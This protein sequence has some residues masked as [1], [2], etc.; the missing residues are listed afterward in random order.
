M[1]DFVVDDLKKWYPGK[2]FSHRASNLF[3][4]SGLL[5]P[6]LAERVK[7]TLIEALPNVLPMFSKQLIAYTE[8]TFKQNKIDLLTKTMVREIKPKSVVVT[9]PNGERIE[10]PF[11]L[12]VW[13]GGNTLRPITKDLIAK[14]GQAQTNRRGLTV[15]DHMVLAGSNGSIYSVGDCTATSYAPTAQV[16]AQQG[17]YVGKL[18]NQMAEI[19]NLEAKL[20]ELKR[21]KADLAEIDP[22]NKKLSKAKKIKPFHYSHQGSLALVSLF[23]IYLFP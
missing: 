22:V 7:I 16:A 11:G 1:H 12:L 5:P 20:A 9:N 3:I 4:K 2:N 10:I 6:E 8:R 14:L 17:T 15:D 19:G 18:F 23:L 13:A 21:T